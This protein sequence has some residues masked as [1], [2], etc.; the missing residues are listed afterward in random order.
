MPSG[1]PEASKVSNIAPSPS[2]Q[3]TPEK[4]VY[5]Q[6]ERKCAYFSGSKTKPSVYDW[7][8]NVEACLRD[9]CIIERRPS[10]F[11]IIWRGKL[12]QKFD[13]AL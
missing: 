10:S 9:R 4:F 3:A 13:F 6:W 12:K 11:M 7:I 2:S 1:A 5:I 8:E